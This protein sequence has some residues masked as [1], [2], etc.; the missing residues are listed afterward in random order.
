MQY[1]LVSLE[2]LFS[3]VLELAALGEGEKRVCP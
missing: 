1:N 3:N 2:Q